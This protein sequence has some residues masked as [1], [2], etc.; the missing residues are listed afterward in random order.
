[1]AFWWLI[2]SPLANFPKMRRENEAKVAL[3]EGSS[4][5]SRHNAHICGKDAEVNKNDIDNTKSYHVPDQ[6]FDRHEKDPSL[7]ISLWYGVLIRVVSP[8]FWSSEPMMC[9]REREWVCVGI[10]QIQEYDRVDVWVELQ[11]LCRLDHHPC[12][13]RCRGW[14]GGTINKQLTQES[15]PAKVVYDSM[16]KWFCLAV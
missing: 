10:V 1:M 5:H 12:R 16:W 7:W 14:R 4:W 2:H 15:L 9:V 8:L 6:Y 3:I 11:F 13:R